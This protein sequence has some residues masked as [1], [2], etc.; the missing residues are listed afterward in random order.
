MGD[1]RKTIKSDTAGIGGYA[2]AE[3]G[4]VNPPQ[5][6]AFDRNELHAR[7]RRIPLTPDEVSTAGVQPGSGI[8]AELG[9]RASIIRSSSH[10]AN[11]SKPK[12]RD[13]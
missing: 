13:S 12:T 3:P 8:N 7:L 2:G 4:P 5:G 6:Y 10:R 9:N 11:V 1:L